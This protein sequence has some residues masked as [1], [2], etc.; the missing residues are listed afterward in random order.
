VW[1]E[2]DDPEII[3]YAIAQCQICP[4]LEDCRS[5]VDSLKPSK[6][7]VGVIAGRVVHD[8]KKEAV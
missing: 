8:H 5:F 1:D 4:V 3:E 2:T 6:R 7:P